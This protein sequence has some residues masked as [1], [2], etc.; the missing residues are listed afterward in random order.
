MPILVVYED[1]S[2]AAR[3]ISVPGPVA[4]PMVPIQDVILFLTANTPLLLPEARVSAVL[5]RDA[6][7]INVLVCVVPWVL[8]R[9]Q[10]TGCGPAVADMG[11]SKLEFKSKGVRVPGARSVEAGP[12][13][14]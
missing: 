10:L 14:R 11:L 8:K 5:S 12:R 7:L 13:S 6:T 1:G 9:V 4:G 3:T 2:L